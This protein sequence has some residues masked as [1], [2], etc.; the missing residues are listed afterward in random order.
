MIEICETDN[1]DRQTPTGQTRCRRCA[2][3]ERGTHPPETHQTEPAPHI[4][5]RAPGAGRVEWCY[6][7]ECPSKYA[8]TRP[9]AYYDET[10]DTVTVTAA[11]FDAYVWRPDPNEA[12]LRTSPDRAAAQLAQIRQHADAMKKAEDL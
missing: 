2:A 3:I 1:C 7:H 10:S 11:F 5:H 8:R 9:D 6:E 12:T 4:G